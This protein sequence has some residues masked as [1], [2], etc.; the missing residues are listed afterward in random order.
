VTIVAA[1]A[2]AGAPL[3]VWL[4]VD[5]L[6]RRPVDDA[7]PSTRPRF[8]STGAISSRSVAIAAAAAAMTGL[9]TRWPV[10]AAGA[11]AVVIAAPTLFGSRAAT[12]RVI[13]RT[14]AVAAWTEML[15]DTIAG[16]HGLEE[17]ITI[18]A[19]VA[20]V[21]IRS[22]VE[23][24][25]ERL[26]REPLGAALRI[27]GAD[28][29]H[30][31]G[32]LVVTALTLAA[33]GAVGDLNDLLGTLAA[34]AREETAMR[35]RVEASRARLHTAVRVIAGCTLGFA[36]S[37]IAFNRSYLDAYAGALG[38]IVLLLIA[39]LWGA[40]LWWLTRLGQLVSP[41]RFLATETEA[42]P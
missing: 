35:L 18:S 1:L 22:E 2:A 21:P 27:F 28:L 10:G 25:A 14:E 30:P 16:A 39:G 42:R 7:G 20:P 4:L 8:R 9:V 15:R 6:R 40:S 33:E 26:R 3:G 32:D 38:Q 29:A 11:A 12:A 31:T 34:S 19:A 24:L 5:G 17:T 37:L 41:E 13:A 36:G 23:A